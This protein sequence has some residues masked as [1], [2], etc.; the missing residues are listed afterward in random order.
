L[1]WLLW[2]STLTNQSVNLK[3]PLF[4]KRTNIWMPHGKIQLMFVCHGSN[5]AFVKAPPSTNL[6]DKMSIHKLSCRYCTF[7]HI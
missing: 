5:V 6:Q 4:P 2:I 3:A 7:P 1:Q